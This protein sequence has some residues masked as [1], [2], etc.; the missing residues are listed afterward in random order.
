MKIIKKTK[1]IQKF[2]KTYNF[3]PENKAGSYM[4]IAP[5]NGGFLDE[6]CE[7]LNI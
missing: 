3:L 7:T 5:A 1:I 4:K 6:K 2:L